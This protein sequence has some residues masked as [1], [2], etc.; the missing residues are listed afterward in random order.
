MDWYKNTIIKFRT[1]S[2]FHG[3]DI[4]ISS[5]FHGIGIFL[6]SFFGSMALGVSFGLG[7]SL[8][9]K[10]SSLNL[11]PGIES[12]LVA[13]IAYTSY[14]FS[15]GLHMSGKHP[16]IPHFKISL[17]CLHYDRYRLLALLW[18]HSKTLC[19]PHN[20]E[21]YSTHHQVHVLNTGSAVRKFHFHLSGSQSLHP[22]R[23]SLQTPLH[24]SRNSKDAPVPYGSL[25][26]IF[27]HLS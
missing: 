8:M 19:L 14:F 11:Y 9:L 24:F 27:K 5:L 20:V 17:I 21:T 2:Q 1:L 18:Y 12:C 25:N 4:Y 26:L 6:F 23:T 7:C 10:H 22:G 16:G 13:L 3:T 15:N